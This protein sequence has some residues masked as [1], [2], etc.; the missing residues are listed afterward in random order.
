MS[1]LRLRLLLLRHDWA[2]NKVENSLLRFCQTALAEG[3]LI[4]LPMAT[5]EIRYLDRDASIQC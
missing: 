3:R 1:I 4:L 5:S 2:L